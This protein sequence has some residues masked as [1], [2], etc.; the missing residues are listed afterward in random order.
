MR[1][2]N[3]QEI[4]DKVEQLKPVIEKEWPPGLE[5]RSIEKIPAKTEE[6]FEKLLDLK[7]FEAVIQDRIE[8]DTLKEKDSL[9]FLRNQRRFQMKP[10]P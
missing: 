5:V 9:F 6:P 4:L 1:R 10:L 7:E 2:S 3:Y 8:P